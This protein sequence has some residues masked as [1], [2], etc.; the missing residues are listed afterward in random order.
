MDA[1]AGRIGSGLTRI[2]GKITFIA[3]SL[4]FS[5]GSLAVPPRARA[6]ESYTGPSLTETASL[7][8]NSPKE[9]A[10]KGNAKTL[11][12]SVGA[13]LSMTSGNSDTI[14]WN[15]SFDLNRKFKCGHTVQASGLYLRGKENDKLSLDRLKLSLRDDY[16]IK[17]SLVGFGDL[18]YKR[19][20]LKGVDHLVNP[21]GGLGWKMIDGNRI[22]VQTDAGAGLLQER[23]LGMEKK[24]SVSI[25]S[26]QSLSY[27]LSKTAN[28]KQKLAL[29]WKAEDLE[30]YLVNL[31][32][33]LATKVTGS[34]ELQAEFL[35]DFKN[36]PSDIT[37]KKNDI[38]LI[39]KYVVRF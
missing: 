24:T 37:Y 29:L 12:G 5:I 2:S 38:A 27:R 3:F 25:N 14:N 19:D 26:N 31:S 28:V 18:V 36:K 16:A 7:P 35:D 30:D 22:T 17:D 33:T 39:L 4:I 8:S 1:D 13:G 32:L 15:I 34:S 11:T 10:A 21:S 9:Q 20:P 23:N 6:A